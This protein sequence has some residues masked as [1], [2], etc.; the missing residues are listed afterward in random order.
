MF[1]VFC[2]TPL[3][4]HF[5]PRIRGQINVVIILGHVKQMHSVENCNWNGLLVPE[6]LALHALCRLI[7]FFIVNYFTL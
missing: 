5:Y 4:V 1:Q 6:N 3:F 2:P 7:N